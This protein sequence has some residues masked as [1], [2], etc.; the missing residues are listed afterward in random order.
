V[1]GEA[2]I[3]ALAQNANLQFC[4]AQLQTGAV[5]EST[6]RSAGA[7]AS[8]I[9]AMI[10]D[11]DPLAKEISEAR[12]KVA[13]LKSDY[14]VAKRV[15]DD[16]QAETERQRTAVAES[17]RDY[18]NCSAQAMDAA[19]ECVGQMTA[20]E[21]AKKALAEFVRTKETPAYDA[22]VSAKN[23]YEREN[24]MLVAKNN[25]YTEA[26]APALELQGKL[27]E[28]NSQVYDLFKQYSPLE[29]ATGQIVYAVQWDKL[30]NGYRAANPE[31]A[32]VTWQRVPIKDAR[33]S[34]TSKV[35]GQQSG[36]LPALLWATLPG[37]GTFGVASLK[38]SSEPVSPL[39]AVPSS[40]DLGFATIGFSNSV[41]GQVGLSLNGACP[42]FPRGQD[43]AVRVIDFQAFT[44]HM[45][46]NA[47][48]VY[49]VT[50]R[51][52]Y[53]ATY[54]LANFL[55]R[56]ERNVKKGGFFSTSTIHSLVVDSSSSDWFDIKFDA[57]G[58]EFQ[59]S[60][61]EQDAITRDV[62]ASLADR[63]LR[64]V[65]AANAAI[66]K[67]PGMPDMPGET[68]AG[69]LARDMRS[70]CGFHIYCQF[71]SMILGT[72]N[73]IFGQTSAVSDFKQYNNVW[74]TERVR[75]VQVL[76]RGHAVTFGRMAT[77]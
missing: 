59:Y 73:N 75:G 25:Q 54:H 57:E 58:S 48:Y 42:Y 10:K 63:A 14:D 7:I 35:P 23:Q 28:L 46:A 64:N 37:A 32:H 47:S 26:L 15:F 74:L 27:F 77:P 69:A 13:A 1:V 56:V 8:R 38:T 21:T 12:V 72:L 18:R 22:F 30:V 16:A 11:Y 50:V 70:T 76:E 43:P 19:R 61:E 65:A 4:P 41:S 49:E 33:L 5:A 44:A 36:G 9:E 2:R 17:V 53:T 24:A 45:V 20:V 68:G 55:S 3:E 62:K 31:L 40:T 34:A 67:A 51:R 66:G 52:G 39:G 29:G 71:G 6:M 60:R